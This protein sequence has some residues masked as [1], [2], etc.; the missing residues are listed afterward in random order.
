MHT[1]PV[2]PYLD[3][4]TSHTAFIVFDRCAYMIVTKLCPHLLTHTFPALLAQY[5]YTFIFYFPFKLASYTSLKKVSLSHLFL[6]YIFLIARSSSP[7]LPLPFLPFSSSSYSFCILLFFPFPNLN[8]NDLF[9][10]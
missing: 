4:L 8:T 7:F 3:S 1:R 5:A 9:L 2:N 10:Q 6:T